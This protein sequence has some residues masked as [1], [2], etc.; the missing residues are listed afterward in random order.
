VAAVALLGVAAPPGSE[1][2]RLR[3]DPDLIRRTARDIL[4]QSE[5]RSPARPL[6]A[7]FLDALNRFLGRV[8]SAAVQ[9]GGNLAGALIL[10]GLLVVLVLVGMRYLRRL[11]P[12]PSRSVAV[13]HPVR[14]RPADWEAEARAHEAAGRW[15][16]ALRCRYGGLV[17]ELAGRGLVTEDSPG[18]TSGEYRIQLD[19][20]APDVALEFDAATELFERAWYGGRKTGPD[21]SARFAELAGAVLRHVP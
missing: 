11:P 6:L 20:A 15:A 8:L 16:D 3:H 2:P 18:R 10:L 14:R 1:L 9:A 5:F 21:D 4:S 7:R 19:T 12:D 17:A 13:D